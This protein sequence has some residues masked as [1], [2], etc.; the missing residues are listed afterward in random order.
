MHPRIPITFIPSP[1]VSAVV[2]GVTGIHETGFILRAL[3]D[4]SPGTIYISVRTSGP[5]APTD[6]T[7][8]RN[9]TGA[10][11]YGSAVN[12]WGRSFV[13]RDLLPGTQYY[14][15]IYSDTGA[16]TP[17]ESAGVTTTALLPEPTDGKAPL[18]LG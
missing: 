5:Y 4:N 3:G 18:R 17:V 12:A 7:I 2:E 10:A 11:W 1:S 9:G 14:Y 15:G 16:V 8:V 13:V 6:Q